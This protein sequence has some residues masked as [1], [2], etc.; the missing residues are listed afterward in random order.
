VGGA[1]PVERHESAVSTMQEVSD[2][3]GVEVPSDERGPRHLRLWVPGAGLIADA[4]CA[5][6]K[7]AASVSSLGRTRTLDSHASRLRRRIAAVT[8]T[9]YVLHGSAGH[10]VQ[11]RSLP[12]LR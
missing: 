3:L 11:A 1:G 7:N 8:D 5:E 10:T 2:G 12:P 4:A 6:P 9:P